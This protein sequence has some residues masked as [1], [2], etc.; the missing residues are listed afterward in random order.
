MRRLF[1]VGCFALCSLVSSFAW[2]E[3]PSSEDIKRA[4]VQYDIGRERYRAGSYTEAAERFEAADSYAP[5]APALR[6]AMAARKEAGQW[7]RAATLAALAVERHPNE[8]DLQAEAREILSEVEA[9]LGRVNVTCDAPCELLLNDRLVHGQASETHIVY[10]KPGTVVLRAGWSDERSD[11]E[12]LDVSAGEVSEVFFTAPLFESEP[13]TP[14][15]TDFENLDDEEAQVEEKKRKGWKPA[16]FWTELVLTGVGAGATVGLGL[17]AL[18]NPGADQVR[19][20]CIENDKSCLTFKEGRRNQTYAN[21]ALG[22]TIGLGVLT[23]ITGIFLTDWGAKK[24]DKKKSEEPVRPT[25]EDNWGALKI[26]PVLGID[27]GATIG[28]RGVF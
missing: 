1:F 8:T 7:E 21:V 17:N 11:S 28:A 19:E 27:H 16:V 5:S 15:D 13:T 12:R 9:R 3:A 2:A 10:I 18:N 22:T 26:Q 14:A 23:A 6:L 25:W 20:K 24:A 4:A